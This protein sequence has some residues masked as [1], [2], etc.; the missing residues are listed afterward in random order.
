MHNRSVYKVTLK[1]SKM[2]NYMILSMGSVGARGVRSLPGT[3][4]R[5]SIDKNYYTFLW[6]VAK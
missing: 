4:D 5:T 6:K 1:S 3:R 2:I